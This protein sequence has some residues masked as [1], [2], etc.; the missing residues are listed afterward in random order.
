MP[1]PDANGAQG[2]QGAQGARPGDGTWGLANPNPCASL[3][4]SRVYEYVRNY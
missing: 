3:R 2:A 4:I 1:S